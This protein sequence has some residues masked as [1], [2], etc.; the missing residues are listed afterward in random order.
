M[1]YEHLSYIERLE[2]ADGRRSDRSPLQGYCN[3]FDM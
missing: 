1:S 2:I 3:R